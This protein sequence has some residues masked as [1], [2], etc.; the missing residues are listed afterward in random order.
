MLEIIA[1]T[2]LTLKPDLT[3]SD[4]VIWIASKNGEFSSQTAWSSIRQVRNVV[5]WWKLVWFQQ[6]VPRWAVIQWLCFHQKLSTKDRLLS[7][8]VVNEASCVL[9][10]GAVESHKHLFFECSY[11]RAV[12][13][14]ILRY[15]M[16]YR[17]PLSLE[18]EVQWSL[19]YRR[20]KTFSTKVYKLSL[21]VVIYHIWREGMR[22][23]L[24]VKGRT[25]TLYVG[26]LLM[27]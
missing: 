17:D 15:N 11:S 16:I 9:C 19:T 3:K 14:E 8:N 27:Q 4:R 26:R 20:G 6:H 23:F 13:R 24:K 18:G 25:I 22:G 21:A 2:P 10:D 5:D 7:W 1:N 12:W